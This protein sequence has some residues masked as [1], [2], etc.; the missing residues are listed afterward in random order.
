MATGAKAA[1]TGMDWIAMAL[2][3]F[4]LPAVLTLALGALC[5]RL[6]FIREGDLKLN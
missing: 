4:I 3:C 2:I 6:G 1:I 5:R